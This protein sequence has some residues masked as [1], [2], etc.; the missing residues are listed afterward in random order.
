MRVAIAG[1]SGLLG[2]AISHR[3]RGEGAQITRL[4]R[5][6]AAASDPDSAYWSPA[7]GAIDAGSLASHTAVINLAGEN[8]FGIWT[9]AKKDRIYRSRVEG[10]RLLAIAL[11]GLPAEDRPE[12]LINASAVG[13]Y[14]SQPPD[15]PLTEERP[16]GDGFMATVVRD[17]EEATAPA[18][19]AGIRVV[20]P[21]FALVL[22][23]D[24]ILLQATS[25]STRLGLGAT[26]GSGR[27]AF[28][29]VSR[30]DVAGVVLFAIRRPD[31]H[32]PVNVAAPQS[33]TN[34]EF[35]DTL[36][37]VLSRPRFL[38]IPAPL[39]RLLGDLGRELLVSA[40]VVPKRLDETGYDWADPKLEPAL[41]RLLEST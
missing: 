6:R 15:E 34:R 23:P 32:G 40:R 24:G 18:A 27:Q 3:L 39:F 5:S 26:L 16:A 37:R 36:A 11:A 33:V 38:S 31:V 22:D 30:D 9:A 2:T 1:A 10:T 8:I 19:D 4:V 35:A 13:Y 20:L 25:L 28:P 29:W 7:D 21:R 12:V 41:R 14:G 17:W